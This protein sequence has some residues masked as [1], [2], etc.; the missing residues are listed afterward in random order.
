ME[1]TKALVSIKTKTAA[2]ALFIMLCP[3]VFQQNCQAA[4][5]ESKHEV[6]ASQDHAAPAMKKIQKNLEPNYLDR[7][8]PKNP[9]V[10][11]GAT[12]MDSANT[13]AVRWFEKMDRFVV[14]AKITPTENTILNTP[15][16]REIE[17]VKRYTETTAEIVKRYRTLVYKLKNMDVP[18]GHPGLKEYCDLTA[19]WYSDAAQVYEDMITKRVPAA[20][21]E[22]LD[23]Q[24]DDVIQRSRALKE[25]AKSLKA[26]DLDLR[27]KYRVH[28]RKDQDA[29]QRFIKGQ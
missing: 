16:N 6:F 8:K 19:D 11:T 14:T 9:V 13:P 17:R 24:L 3:V 21:V 12:Y 5:A 29:L 15:M 10:E 22:D 7:Y 18:K 2:T 23:E 4:R 20:T 1:S 25:T 27:E 26:M 28:F